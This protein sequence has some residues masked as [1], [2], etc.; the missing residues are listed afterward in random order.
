MTT[1]HRLRTALF[2]AAL[3]V[4]APLGGNTVSV[5]SAPPTVLGSNLTGTEC[6]NMRSE[7]ARQGQY[8]RLECVV[9]DVPAAANPQGNRY[10]LYGYR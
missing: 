6:G 1:T 9:V 2:A 5:A 7:Y 3:A 8:R 4:L 10:N